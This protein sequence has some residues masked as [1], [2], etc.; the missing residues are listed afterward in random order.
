M[1]SQLETFYIILR[2]HIKGSIFYYFSFCQ[3]WHVEKSRK[4]INSLEILIAFHIVKP[5]IYILL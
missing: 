4:E 2:R 1:V 3:S 5:S